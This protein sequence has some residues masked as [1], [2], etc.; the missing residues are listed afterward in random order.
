MA[1]EIPKLFGTSG[2]RGKIGSDI[3]LEVAVEI[4]MAI[5]TYTGGKGSKIVLGYDSR[6][7]NVMIENAVTAGLLQC[8]CHVLKMGMAPTPLVG[9]A[10]M[11]LEANAGVMITASHNPPE[12]NGIKLWN[13]DG[14][15]Y[16]Q[17]QE[18]FIEE[19]IHKKSFKTVSWEDIGKVVE[20][21][22]VV[23]EYIKDILDHVDIKPGI[24]VVVDCANGAASYLSPI[25]LRKAGCSV[26]AINSQPD[27][28]FPGRLPEPSQKN[29]QELMKVVKATGADIGIAHDGDADR[30]I[31]IDEK[32]RMADFDKLLAIV[33]REIGGTVV[34]TVD[35]SLCTDKCMDEVGGHVIRT[36]VGDVH[37]AEAIE[38]NNAT[39]GGEPSG[40]WLHPN[41]C[42]CPDGILSALRVIELVQKYGSLSKQLD[43]VPS[44]PTIRDR[45]NCENFQKEPIMG[46]VEE[47]L[48]ILLDNVVDVN[49]IDGVRITLDDGSWVLIRPSG[50]ESFIRITLEATSNEKAHMIRN[51]CAEFIEGLL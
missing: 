19:I 29:L 8:G 47:E 32:G 6:T 38:G 22:Y 44:Y 30:M 14:M 39:F 20:V 1:S 15:A 9:Y 50:T 2:I 3:S 37:V 4:G 41:F 16:R 36:K 40:T 49:R 21:N 28:F 34:T 42:M 5:A 43:A 33:S 35:A 27:G 10:T 12:Y 26:V 11:K 18:R 13:P 24:K 17:E 51:Q 25:I 23:S 7:S 46:K 48:H 45:V 31:A